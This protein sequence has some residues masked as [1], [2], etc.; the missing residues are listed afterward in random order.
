MLPDPFARPLSTGTV[1]PYNAKASAAFCHD[2]RGDMNEAAAGGSAARIRRP[3][4]SASTQPGLSGV[5]EPA[6]PYKTMAMNSDAIPKT[7]AS[8][9]AGQDSRDHAMKNHSSCPDD[10]AG[11]RG[12]HPLFR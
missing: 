6:T 10:N 2:A 5:G 12:I 7:G 4:V 8:D 9:A 3:P 1:S 11:R